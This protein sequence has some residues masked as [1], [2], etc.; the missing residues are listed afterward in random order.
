MKEKSVVVQPENT[1]IRKRVGWLIRKKT[2]N[3]ITLIKKRDT[4]DLFSKEPSE[5]EKLYQN[6][7]GVE[8]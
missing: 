8:K 4:L 6:H 2:K 1:T 3:I 7:A 5:M